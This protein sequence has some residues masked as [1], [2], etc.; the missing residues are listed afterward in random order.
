MEFCRCRDILFLGLQ[1][2]HRRLC[3]DCIGRRSGYKHFQ[4]DTKMRCEEVTLFRSQAR[5]DLR[6]R[7]GVIQ[8]GQVAGIAAFAD[9]G[10]RAA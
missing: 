4:V 9:G 2:M 1:V 10:N 8:R 6:Q 7:R 5:P 3:C